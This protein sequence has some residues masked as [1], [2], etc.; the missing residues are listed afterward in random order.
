MLYDCYM[1]FSVVSDF[2]ENTSKSFIYFGGVKKAT[3]NQILQLFDF[4]KGNMPFRYFEAPLS[5]KKISISQCQPLMEKNY[6]YND[7]IDHKYLSYSE[8]YN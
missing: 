5:T 3:M 1:R 6:T 7:F 2:K 8:G 4:S